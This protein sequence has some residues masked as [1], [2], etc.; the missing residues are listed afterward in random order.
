MTDPHDGTWVE[1]TAAELVADAMALGVEKV[2]TRM[3]A[4]WVGDGLL[5]S[6]GFRKSTRH[7]SDERVFSPEQRWLFTELLK[8]RQRSSLKRIPHHTLTR[9]VLYLWLVEDTVVPTEQ[10]R[11]AWRTYARATGRHTGPGRRRLAQRVVEQLAHPE[12]TYRQRRTALLLIEAGEKSKQPDWE[13]LSPV[14]AQL[15]SPWLV[16]GTPRIERSLGPAWLPGTAT[17]L[18][19]MW[20]AT[21]QVTELLLNKRIKEPVLDEVRAVFRASWSDYQ[22]RR[23]GMAAASGEY[24]RMFAPP[25]SAEARIKETVE[26]FVGELAG[27]LGFITAAMEAADAGAVPERRSTP[28]R[29][30]ALGRPKSPVI[31]EP[32]IPDLSR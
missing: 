3:V 11:R 20:W 10:A 2:S 22:A 26:A 19:G 25:A 31:H 9:M 7:G 13:K 28:K 27:V 8:A 29:D 23:A 16:P 21:Q 32:T 30:P 14:I 17:Q 1:G 15:A 4:D 12:A 5:A 18:V 6:P 24:G